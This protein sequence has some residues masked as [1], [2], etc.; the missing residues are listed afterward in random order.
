MFAQTSELICREIKPT[1][2]D[3]QVIAFRRVKPTS[4]ITVTSGVVPGVLSDIV[5]GGVVVSDDV[6]ERFGRL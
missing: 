3:H 4:D 6:S 5:P 2:E 1:V